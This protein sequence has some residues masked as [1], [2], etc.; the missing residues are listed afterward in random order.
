MEHRACGV[1]VAS[2]MHTLFPN[3]ARQRE[4]AEATH[5]WPICRYLMDEGEDTR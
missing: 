4:A 2:S 5:T 1:S 3:R